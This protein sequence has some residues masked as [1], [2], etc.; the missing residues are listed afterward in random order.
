MYLHIQIHIRIKQIDNWCISLYNNNEISNRMEKTVKGTIERFDIG[1]R[2]CSIYLPSDYETGACYPVVYV[3]GTDELP[4]IIT[5]LEPHVGRDCEPFMLLNVETVNWN[6]DMT[7]WPSPALTKK[8]GA[9]GGCADTY[10]NTLITEIKPF[11]DTRYRTKPEPE[12]TGLLGYSL[13]GLTALYALYKYKTF[14]MIGCLSGSLWYENWL[15]FVESHQPQNPEA[16]VYIS[17]GTKEKESKNERMAAVGKCTDKAVE[18]L[19]GQLSD[20]S[21]I[22]LEWNDGGHFTEIPQRFC[23]A[24]LWLMRM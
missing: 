21:C 23:R 2:H 24:F 6:D 22:K 9:F 15:G 13:G 5:V 18:I 8:S 4:E 14:G 10:L 1:G 19:G 7:P 11:V 3:N 16:K 12:S 17:L 20:I